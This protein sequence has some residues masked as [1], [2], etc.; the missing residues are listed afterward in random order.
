MTTAWD[1]APGLS[2][3]SRICSM[4]RP[5]LAGEGR[6]QVV[7]WKSVHLRCHVDLPV[8]LKP[9]GD[10]ETSIHPAQ[11]AQGPLED[12]SRGGFRHRGAAKSVGD[13]QERRL[14]PVSPLLQNRTPR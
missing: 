14:K 8:D 7:S 5:I 6:E 10:P 12:L 11:R 1:K 9:S 3:P 13:R 4:L 2:E